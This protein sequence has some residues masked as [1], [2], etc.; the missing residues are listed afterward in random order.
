MWITIIL[1]FPASYCYLAM[2]IVQVYLLYFFWGG[3]FW[4]KTCLVVSFSGAILMGVLLSLFYTHTITYLKIVNILGLF[5][6]KFFHKIIFEGYFLPL[7]GKLYGVLAYFDPC[8]Q[9]FVR[10]AHSR[11][12]FDI[13]WHDILLPAVTAMGYYFGSLLHRPPFYWD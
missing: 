13:V 10:L 1:E 8:F 12:V 7:W 3:L 11:N 5:W 6:K 9:H 4:R 2:G